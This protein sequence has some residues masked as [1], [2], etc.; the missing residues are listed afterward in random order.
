MLLIW[1]GRMS[2]PADM[3]NFSGLACRLGDVSPTPSLSVF[4]SIIF[5]YLFER[6]YDSGKERNSHTIRD[7]PLTGSLPR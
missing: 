3:D 4:F 7:C 6:Q 1:T 2:M 5:N